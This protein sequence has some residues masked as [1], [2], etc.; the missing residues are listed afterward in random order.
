VREELRKEYY[1]LLSKIPWQ[2][3]ATFTFP[4]NLL[5]GDEE[6]RSRWQDFM[7]ELEANHPDTI[8]RAVAEESRHAGALL[9]GIRLHYHALLTSDV[10]LNANLIRRL[11][12]KYSGNGKDLLDLRRYQVNGGAEYYLLKL[13]GSAD[14]ELTLEHC[15]LFQPE[16]P[17]D[18]NRN[19]RTRR[20]WRRQLERRAARN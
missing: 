1:R 9:S 5:N 2:W 20:R 13:L 11:W 14:G 12:E 19:A 4:R 18:W 8:A 16:G 7:R 3:Y 6:A 10:P 17:R 15:D